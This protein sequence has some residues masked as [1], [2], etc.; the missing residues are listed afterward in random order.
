MGLISRV[1]SRTYRKY[2]NMVR[3]DEKGNIVSGDSK[4]SESNT[5]SRPNTYQTQDSRNS[6]GGPA[7]SND[8]F[9]TENSIGNQRNN[10][11]NEQSIVRLAN[12]KLEELGVP[13]WRLTNSIIIPQISILTMLV[14]FLLWQDAK[15]TFIL[16]LLTYWFYTAEV[17]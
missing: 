3:I 16:G 14:T 5:R 4:K 12:K 2:K 9:E 10:N 13:Q 6:R 17:F 15:S 8:F 7:F 11:N 1:S